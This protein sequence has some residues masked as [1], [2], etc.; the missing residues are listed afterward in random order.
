MKI[1]FIYSTFKNLR[2]AKSISSKLVKNKLAACTNIIPKIYS[3]YIWKN[4]TVVDKE[5]SIIIKTTKSKVKEVIKFI[6]KR[7]TYDCPAV[8]S[9]PI[10]YTHKDFKQWVIAQTKQ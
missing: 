1:Y 2:E 10:K 5:C 9:F 3:T 8:T 4:K 6:V 7:H